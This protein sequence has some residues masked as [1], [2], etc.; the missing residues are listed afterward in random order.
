MTFVLL[1]TAAWKMSIPICGQKPR[2]N[3]SKD[4]PI[5]QNLPEIMGRSG[6]D[7]LYRF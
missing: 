6:N 4:I 3:S 5:S 2:V 7:S 1:S